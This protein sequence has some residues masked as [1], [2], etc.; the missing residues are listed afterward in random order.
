MTQKDIERKSLI[1]S[2]ILN[3]IIAGAGIWVFAVTHIQALFLDCFFSFIAFISTIVAV[4][5]NKVSNKRT[6]SFPDGLYFLEPLYAIFK[7]L[8]TLSLLVISV[9]GTAIPAYEYFVYGTGKPMNIGPVL[10][11]TISMVILCFGL[12]FYNIIQNK[13]INHTS[14]ILTAE[15]KSNLIDGL[16]SL[17]IGVAV[18]FLYFVDVNGSLGFFYYTGDF[19]ITFILALVS[20]KLPIKVLICAFRELLGGTTDDV[21]IKKNIDAIVD[22]YLNKIVKKKRCEI[23]KVGMHI[24]VRVSLQSKI[25]H[26]VA[27]ELEKAREKIISDLKISYKSLELNYNF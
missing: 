2:S 3:F 10:P 21:I 5:I 27:L 11:Y 8:L 16:Q 14:T 7:S 9:V 17:G 13:K 24:K 23:F 15:S 4:V 18:A 22:K 26:D 12:G 6:I 20:L 19:F 1:V 25:S